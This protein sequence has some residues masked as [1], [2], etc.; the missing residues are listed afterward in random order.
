MF[1]QPITIYNHYHDIISQTDKY[2]RTIVLKTHF[3]SIEGATLGGVE[4]NTDNTYKV[5]IPLKTGG[6]VPPNVYAGVGWTLK[7][8]DYIVKG[9]CAVELDSY[10]DIQDLTSMVINKVEVNDYAKVKRLNN[11]TALGK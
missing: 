6:Y 11:Y 9:V 5:V 7:P 3:E 4:V 8:N 10:A 2:K 1:T